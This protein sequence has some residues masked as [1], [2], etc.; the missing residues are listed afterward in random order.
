M[1]KRKQV[2]KYMLFDALAAAGAWA[3]FY[4]YRKLYIEKGVFDQFENIHIDSNFWVALFVIPAF[5]LAIYYVSGFYKDIYRRSRLIDFGHTFF[6]SLAG[7]V[8]IFFTLMLDDA[9]LNYK[10]YYASF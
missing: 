5:W 7:V 1:D 8:V 6:S 3:L 9:I 4:I 10:N 2:A